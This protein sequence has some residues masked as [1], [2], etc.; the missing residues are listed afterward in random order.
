[1][2]II[3]AIKPWNYTS[4]MINEKNQKCPD[5]KLRGM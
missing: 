5:E 2:R 1:M 4:S 3:K